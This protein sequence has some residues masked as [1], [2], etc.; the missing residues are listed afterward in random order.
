MKESLCEEHV[1]HKEYT[2][3]ELK[4]R[5]FLFYKLGDLEM[6]RD[7]AQEAFIRLWDNCA[8]VAID[9]VKGFLFT[10][11]NRL[12]LDHYDHQKVVLKFEHR[13]NRSEG[14]ME[15]N[16]E[17]IYQEEEFKERLESAVSGLPEKQRV[18]FLMS[19]I[20]KF[21]NREI[22]EIMDLSIKTVE[23]H[24]STAVKSLKE[25]LDELDNLKV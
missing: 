13:M 9:K 19:R 16:P 22:A 23:K 20:D 14:Q 3:H 24:I 10:T 6:A 12:F 25:N 5:N 18:V 11:A 4:V 2:S 15:Q 7:F 8:K 17:F 1:F 21:K